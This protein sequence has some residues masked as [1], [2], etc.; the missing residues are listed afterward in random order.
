MSLHPGYAL[1][2]HLSSHGD[3]LS[4]LGNKGYSS[5]FA[6]GEMETQKLEFLALSLFSNCE[7][8]PYCVP[9]PSHQT[10]SCIVPDPCPVNWG[11]LGV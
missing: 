9:G 11:L 8:S 10:E 4:P 6:D 5:H 2:S 3:P 7:L 1:L